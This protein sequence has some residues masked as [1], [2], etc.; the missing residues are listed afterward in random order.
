MRRKSG[1]TCVFT[2]CVLLFLVGCSHAI[3]TTPA[4]LAEPAGMSP[5]APSVEAT[6]ATEEVN[7][8]TLSSTA[9][10]DGGFIGEKYAY[11]MGRQ[12]SGENYSPPLAWKDAPAG[13]QSLLLTV[14]DPDGGNWVHWLLV[15]I[16]ADLTSLS[17]EIGGP[18]VG[19]SG[20]ND[21]GGLGYGG[22]CPPSGTHHY[23]FTLYALDTILE[24]KPGLALKAVSSLFKDHVLGKAVLTGLKK[25]K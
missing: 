10:T 19:V 8:F 14:I 9:F 20:R 4:S 22:P 12:C 6:V 25:A 23:V 1:R 18:A 15:N 13:T 2:I 24:I 21:F 7:M 11:K 16:P 3:A 5:T 17:E